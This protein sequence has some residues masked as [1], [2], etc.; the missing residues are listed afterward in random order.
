MDC[1]DEKKNC[2]VASLLKI[3]RGQ[4][5]SCIKMFDE[6][7]YCIDISN[8]ISA[9]IALL[10]KAQTKVIVNH[11]NTCVVKSIEEGHSKEKISEIETLLERII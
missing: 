6:E 4:I 11:L 5:E 10:K 1:C 9:T 3:A 8:Q 2:D 7:R